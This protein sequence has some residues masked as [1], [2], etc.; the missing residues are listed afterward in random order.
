MKK[1][2]IAFFSVTFF[3]TSFSQ[4]VFSYGK[5]VVTKEEFVR[6]FNKNPVAGTDRKKAL[7]EYLNLYINF[8]LK[9]QAAY[10]AG[11]DK[12]AAQQYEL[13]NFKKQ[14]ADNI[15]NDEANVKALVKQAFERS[16]KEIRLQQV[17]IEVPKNT[18]TTEA[19]K[20][21][22]LAYKQLK[23]GKDFGAAAQEFATDE[24]TRQTKGDLGFITAFT[25]PYEIENDV[26]ALKP[27]SF[28]A[29]V[30][31][32]AGYH[33]FKNAGERTSLGSRRIA[34]I[35]VAI[36]PNA[37]I[38]DKNNALHKADSLYNLVTNGND[39]GALA[40]AVSNDLSS[41]N[42]RGELPEFTIG[43]YN[44]DF[45]S[46]AFSLKSKDEISKPFQT[47]YG[48]HILKLL[49]AKPAPTDVS[50]PNTQAVLQ[51]KVNRDRRL[52]L[53]KKELIQKKLAVIKF[54]PS[55]IKFEDLHAY[56]D[57]TITNH[58]LSTIHG[59][60]AGTTLFSFAK[61]NIKADDWVKF[62]K[63]STY[64]PPDEERYKEFINTTADQYYRNNLDDFN[65]EYSTQVKE[66]KEAN[67][68][69]GIMEKNVWAKANTDTAGL[70]E[71]YN[72]HKLKYTWPPSAD[73]IIVTC[74]DEN[75]AKNI[76]EKLKA[77]TEN[78]RQLTGNN[79]TDISADSGRFELGQL[80]VID[81][82]NFTQG[83]FTA[84]VKNQSDNSYTFNYIVKVYNEPAQRSF[85]DAR[86][87]VISDYQQLLE[88]KWISELKKK[89][90]V[91]INEAVFQTIK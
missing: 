91:K 1:L 52:D 19:Y 77:N 63:S 57:S 14:I 22:K 29:P 33:I 78:W 64:F 66:F 59:I 41:S 6:A 24:A 65:K 46:V 85:E 68:L 8:K 11:L 27:N 31:T 44:P 38:E 17:F 30:K 56:T 82:T 2:V 36:P 35:L 75:F 28:S 20:K 51:A 73:A 10:D 70:K 67:M 42:N 25:L 21:I 89:Y 16:R 69:F 12:D 74:K 83:L 3:M 32:K 7:K 43:T 47:A 76:R 45:E 34:Q 71:Y 87:M 79:G 15:I 5:N 18:D 13:Q 61:Q 62:V 90:P 88:T 81:R 84:A 23:D 4:N 50:D 49:E 55:T 58:S 40:A 86:G 53:S 80:P 26:Y 37:T 9:V 48:F 60:N 39:F 54:K 72:Q